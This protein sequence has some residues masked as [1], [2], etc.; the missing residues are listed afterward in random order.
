MT[1]TPSRAPALV[2]AIGAATSLL[3]LGCPEHRSAGNPVNVATPGEALTALDVERVL[4]GAIA[5]AE[6]AGV[7]AA[8]AVTDR[9][10][11]VLGVFLTA[12]RDRDGDGALET[13]GAGNVQAAIAKAATAGA[14]QSEGEAF[15]TRTA[16]FI[17]QGHFPPGVRDTAGGPLFGVQDSSQPSSDVRS[18]AWDQAGNMVGTG[19]SGVLGGVPLY[20]RGAPVGGVGVDVVGSLQTLGG[21]ATLVTPVQDEL[22]ERVARAGAAGLDAPPWIQAT[23]VFVDGIAFPFLGAT[24]PGGGATAASLAALPPG[25]GALD[26]AFPVRPSPLV[27]EGLDGTGKYGLRANHRRVGRVVARSAAGFT[28]PFTNVDRPAAVGF[29]AA[30]LRFTTVPVTSLPARPT[31]GG[32]GEVRVQSIAGVEPPPAEG[33]LTALEVDQIIDRAVFDARRSVAGIRLPR[34]VNVVVHVAVVDV[35]GNLLG[36]LRMTDGTLFSSDVAVQKARTAAFF[37]G[38]GR[39]GQPAVAVSARAIG[40]L[41]QPFFPPGIDGTPPGPLVRLRD[42]VNRGK[43]IVED[44]P[45][46][47]LISPPPRAPSDGTTDEDPLTPGTQTFNDYGGGAPAAE[48]AAIRGIIAATGGVAVL[49]DRPDT[50]PGFISPGL[51]SGMQTFPGGVPLYRGTQLVG[52]IGVSG[53]GVDEDDAASVAGAL[54][55]EP[56]AG[57][58][59]DEVGEGTLATLLIARMD[60]LVAAVQAHP[61]DRIRLVYG[62]LF[63][64]ERA[65]VQARLSLG[66][67]GVRIPWVKLP[68]NPTNP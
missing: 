64:A 30:T 18:L 1:A 24:A 54:G 8:I 3:V 60:R 5:E 26:P 7:A 14:F 41:S 55:F 53:D 17:V 57:I 49:A 16:F 34:G 37:S 52:A 12:A 35:R 63:Q 56:P 21:A 67:S 36:L 32:F 31:S 58:R 51:Q 20:K 61:D 2:L 27:A 43:L 47:T 22:H 11:E 59:C 15:T 38:D 65:R 50:A 40:F 25:A 23:N 19:L 48:L 46:F 13:P 28:G 10:G 68:R 45:S 62:P 29:D 39:D 42:L 33:G 4:L 6:R 44:P 66:L 9:E